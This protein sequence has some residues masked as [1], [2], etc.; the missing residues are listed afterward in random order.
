MAVPPRLLHS[1]AAVS[2]LWL[3]ASFAGTPAWAAEPQPA[4][5]LRLLIPA[6]FY[7]SGDGLKDWDRL[8]D[9]PVHADLVAIVNPADGPGDKADPNYVKIMERAAK[10]DLTLI[11]YVATHYGKR[12]LDEVKADVDR[13]LRL[14]PGVEGIF[15]D[16]QNS[17]ADFVDYQAA[18]YDY[19]RTEKKLK[20][21]VTNP[22][23]TCA[24]A[25]LT[26]PAADVCCIHEN[27]KGFDGL[28]LPDGADKLPASRFAALA[29]Q[30]GTAEAMRAGVADAAKKAGYV[31]LTDAEGDNPWDR[32]P[33]YWDEEVGVVRKANESGGK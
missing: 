26:R 16:E 3:A 18:L 19:V 23:T 10:A 11:G 24:S 15:F 1:A 14:Y 7:P 33:R 25:Y 6:Y 30:V 4:P 28:R 2:L 5:R 31:Y 17:G 20:L 12:P 29:Y 8:L 21:V 32:L 13:W 22:G 27:A 9:S